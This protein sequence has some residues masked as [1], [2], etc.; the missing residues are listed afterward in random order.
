[1]GGGIGSVLDITTYNDILVGRQAET[2]NNTSGT[3][4][5]GYKRVSP[6]FVPKVLINMAA[7]YVSIKHG[8]QVRFCNLGLHVRDQTTHV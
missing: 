1:M 6:Y 7:G 3:T 8:L 4:N 2:K 5:V